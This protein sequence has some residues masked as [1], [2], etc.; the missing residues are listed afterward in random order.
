MMRCPGRAFGDPKPDEQVRKQNIHQAL[1]YLIVQRYEDTA[2]VIDHRS[3]LLSD[4]EA[5]TDLLPMP[6]YLPKENDA[7]E[8]EIV[9][10][11]EQL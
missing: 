5:A 2:I 9:S 3:P 10:A 7:V 6:V 1:K 8:K 4:L 11:I